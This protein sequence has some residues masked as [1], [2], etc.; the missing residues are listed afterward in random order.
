MSDNDNRQYPSMVHAPSPQ[1]S[2]E[3]L[4]QTLPFC[5]S[6]HEVSRMHEQS[7]CA[8]IVCVLHASN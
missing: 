1:S 4:M 7:A 8:H 5:E 6:S 3:L 2:V